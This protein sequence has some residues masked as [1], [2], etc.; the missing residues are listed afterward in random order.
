MNTLNIEHNDYN[1]YDLILI[2]FSNLYLKELTYYGTS[3]NEHMLQLLNL[4]SKLNIL[5]KTIFDEYYNKF[6][7]DYETNEIS[8]YYLI[9]TIFDVTNIINRMVRLMVLNKVDASESEYKSRYMIGC[10]ENFVNKIIQP[11]DINHSELEN[12]LKKNTIF[13]INHKLDYLSEFIQFNQ[14]KFTSKKKIDKLN[15]F[16]KILNNIN[17]NCD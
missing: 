1:D 14:N 13:T 10:L 9:K 3:K 2:K 12:I 8:K 5:E 6:V 16:I 4:G 15:K 7:S 17:K 11:I